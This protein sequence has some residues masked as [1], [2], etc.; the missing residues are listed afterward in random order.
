[1]LSKRWTWFIFT[2][3]VL[4]FLFAFGAVTPTVISSSFSA[5]S[6]STTPC[7]STSSSPRKPVFWSTASATWSSSVTIGRG[8]VRPVVTLKMGTLEQERLILPPR[9]LQKHMTRLRRTL[10]P[11][12]NLQQ[13]VMSQPVQFYDW[14]IMA[15]QMNLVKKRAVLTITWTETSGIAKEIPVGQRLKEQMCLNVC[16]IKFSCVLRSWRWQ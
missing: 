9:I 4:L 13:E 11:V 6:P 15:V 8:F 14:S 2:A 7:S 5:P 16:L 1:M 3:W 12:R 10:L